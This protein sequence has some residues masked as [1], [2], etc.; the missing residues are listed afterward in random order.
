MVWKKPMTFS[1]TLH[2]VADHLVWEKRRHSKVLTQPHTIK[3]KPKQ[4]F[5]CIDVSAGDEEQE[6]LKEE[7]LP[8][9]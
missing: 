5:T 3:I 2:K 8:G 7:L 4:S 6:D 9:G 1:S